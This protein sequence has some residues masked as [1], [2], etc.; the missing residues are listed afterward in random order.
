VAPTRLP[1]PARHVYLPGM[2]AATL[3]PQPI[4]AQRPR[5]VAPEPL[6]DDVVRGLT[7]ELGL[8]VAI[9]RLLARRG[10]SDPERA[11]SFL[12][13]RPEH[14]HLPELMAGMAAAVG[15]L[16]RAISQGETVLVHGDYD[17]DGIC[18]T[19]LLV[20]ALRMM[21]GRAVPFV[22]HRIDDGYD[23]GLAGLAAAKSAGASVILTADCGIVAHE[24]TELARTQGLDVIVTDHHQPGRTLP[25]ALAVINPSRSDC[26]YPEKGLAGAGVAFKLMVAL[27]AESGFPAAR[28]DALLDLVALATIADLAPLGPENRAIVRWGIAVLQRTP[29]VGLR[30]L[31][32]STG[33]GDREEITSG[34]IGFILAPRLNAI[35]RI[36]DPMKGVRLLLTDDSVEASM[37]A[38]ELESVNRQRRDLDET[39]LDEALRMLEDEYDPGR[40]WG[41]VLASPS[42]HPGVIGIVASRVVERIH[43]PTV[44][45]AVGREEGKG[46]GRS[47]PGFHLHEA[48]DHCRS[49]LLRFG[50]HRAAAGCSILPERI[51][52]FRQAFAS[53]AAEALRDE[54]PVPTLRLDETL[55][56]ADADI[57][58][59]RL[60]RHFGPFGIGNP[61]PLFASYDVRLKRPPRIVGGKHL[62]LELTSEGASLAAIGFG[63]GHRID[64]LSGPDVRLDVAFRLEENRWKNPR[65]RSVTSTVQAR[66]ADFRTVG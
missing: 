36:D 10:Y 25:D 28:L 8:P 4:A 19:A 2:P 43:R 37:L 14:L 15:R 50:G 41:V 24:A 60:L 3:P 49:H 46:S 57:A 40:D 29:N 62:Q 21:G 11:R 7:S 34:Q 55:S 54:A 31:L 18:A 38:E 9:C 47:I 59:C 35:G 45:I 26:G 42:W 53:Y 17:V 44:L 5:W 6:S 22:P 16:R 20:R 63:M 33:L 65:S 61:A 1:T 32:K 27:A 13:P 52:A 30:A 48:F 51:D 66:L 56:I 58:I 39:I 64:E 12:R 23:L